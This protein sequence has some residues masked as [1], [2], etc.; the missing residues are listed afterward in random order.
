[1]VAQYSNGNS[2]LETALYA[3]IQQRK[4]LRMKSRNLI[5]GII[6][7]LENFN[8]KLKEI[9]FTLTFC[10]TFLENHSHPKE[11]NRRFGL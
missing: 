4:K 5:A 11:R 8:G 10:L 3:Y 7:F 6:Q 9:N 2:K 1:M